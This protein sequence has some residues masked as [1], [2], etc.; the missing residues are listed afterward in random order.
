M[1]APRRVRFFRCHDMNIAVAYKLQQAQLQALFCQKQARVRM[2][3][4]KH[5]AQSHFKC[6]SEIAKGFLRSARDSQG[7]RD[8]LAAPEPSRDKA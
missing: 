8:H 1:M 7:G 5:S 3:K 4:Q 2:V 6:F